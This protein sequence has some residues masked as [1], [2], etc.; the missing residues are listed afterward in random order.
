V[1]VRLPARKKTE[2]TEVV[3]DRADGKRRK[4]GDACFPGVETMGKRGGRYQQHSNF[5]IHAQDKEIK[6]RRKKKRGGALALIP[7]PCSGKNKVTIVKEQTETSLKK[8]EGKKKLHILLPAFSCGGDKKKKREQVSTPSLSRKR[9]AKSGNSVEDRKERKEDL[10]ISL[11]MEERGKG[12]A[13]SHLAP[14]GGER[15]II[16]AP[17]RKKKEGGAFH[18]SRQRRKGKR[19]KRFLLSMRLRTE[20]TCRRGRG[21]SWGKGRKKRS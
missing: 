1:T 8:R 14:K 6:K 4:K 12:E 9:G 19:M 21:R 18:P 2:K 10:G 3:S 20:K 17:L 15:Q 7:S 5:P 16:R 13:S 11:S